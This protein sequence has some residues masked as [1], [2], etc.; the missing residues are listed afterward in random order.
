MD[1]DGNN[2]AV[3][4][5]DLD[6]EAVQIRIRN[7]GRRVDARTAIRGVGVRAVCRD[8]HS[9]AVGG[10]LSHRVE[11]RVAVYVGGADCPDHLMVVIRRRR[12]RASRRGVVDR[13]DGEA[14]GGGVGA[15]GVG[16]I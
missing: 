7:R 13:G 4:I 2:A 16:G 3:L 5:V 12:G 15:G 6:G 9:A 11:E 8:T 10:L 1:G 14:D